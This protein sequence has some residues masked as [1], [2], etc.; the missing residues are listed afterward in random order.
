[1][2]T[3]GVAATTMPAAEPPLPPRPPGPTD[4]FA[5]PLPPFRAIIVSMELNETEAEGAAL[6]NIPRATPPSRPLDP[7]VGA[8][9]PA[10]AATPL[11]ALLMMF[12]VAVYQWDIPAANVE[13][14]L[15]SAPEGAV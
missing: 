8:P 15:R 2:E 13:R 1:M 6:T 10:W 9:Q 11:I 4:V 3:S 14:T 12:A 7:E 5:A